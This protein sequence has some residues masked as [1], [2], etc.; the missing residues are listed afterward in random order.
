MVL[1]CS[2]RYEVI[3]SVIDDTWGYYRLTVDEIAVTTA[4]DVVPCYGGTIYFEE[5]LSGTFDE[6][7]Q[8]VHKYRFTGEWNTGVTVS[9][10]TTE[11]DLNGF[12]SLKS[13][14]GQIIY[15]DDSGEGTNPLI[16]DAYLPC[17]G[18]WEVSVSGWPNTIGS[19]ALKLTSGAGGNTFGMEPCSIPQGY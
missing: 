10:V 14:D 3:V 17:S 4:T 15:D 18:I 9:V 6:G 16:D 5:T 1:E 12:L 13:P 19:Y 7:S 8:D 11:G 2:G